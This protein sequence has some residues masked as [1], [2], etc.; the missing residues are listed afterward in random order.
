MAGKKEKGH[1]TL[2]TYRNIIIALALITVAEIVVPYL[3]AHD[4][5]S[6]VGIALL[7]VLAIVKYVLVVAFFMHLYYDQP[8]CTFLFVTGMVLGGGTMAGLLS[9]MPPDAFKRDEYGQMGASSQASGPVFPAGV[10]G[11]A[12]AEAGMKLFEANCVTCHALSALPTA[13]GVIGP[14]L[15]GIHERGATRVKGLNAEQYL[16]QSMKDPGAF[17]VE[18]YPNS[19]TNFGFDDAKRK[20][21]VTF[22]MLASKPQPAAGT[23]ASPSPG[24]PATPDPGSGASPDPDVVQESEAS[25]NAGSS[26]GGAISPSPVDST[27]PAASPSP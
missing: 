21:L 3:V 24:V 20:Q 14:S 26:P 12:E 15:D 22:L 10:K 27:E 4:V 13:T 1:A 9:A 23:E 6:V 25:P 16:D 8:L 5:N 11:N 18:G 19:M 2:T 7:V 17:V